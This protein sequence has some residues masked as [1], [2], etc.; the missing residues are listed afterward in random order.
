[1]KGKNKVVILWSLCL[2]VYKKDAEQRASLPKHIFGINIVR[3][4]TVVSGFV[5][6]HLC[7][8]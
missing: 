6:L 2:V 8:H 3:N 1:M 5:V 4:K 7:V